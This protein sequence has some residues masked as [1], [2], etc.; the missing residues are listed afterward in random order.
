MKRPEKLDGKSKAQG[1]ELPYVHN[2]RHPQV[3]LIYCMLS[4]RRA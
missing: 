4:T 2:G 1:E 3:Q